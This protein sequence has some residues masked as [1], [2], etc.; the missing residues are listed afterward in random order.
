[1]F[2]EMLAL[3]AAE[4]YKQGKPSI[5]GRA[6]A[7]LPSKNMPTKTDNKASWYFALQTP[8]LTDYIDLGCM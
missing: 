1:M 4:K 3:F 2:S 6:M 8:P 7:P 5:P